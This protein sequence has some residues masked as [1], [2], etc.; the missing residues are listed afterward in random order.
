MMESSSLK[1]F[2]VLRW[3]SS[4]LVE[5]GRDHNAGEI[6]LQHLLDK[7]RSQLLASLQEPVHVQIQKRFKKAVKLHAAGKPVQ[8]IIGYE[9]FYG[10]RFLVN[11]HV[12]IPRPETEELVLGTLQRIQVA[13]QTR[14]NQKLVDV[15]TG[16]GIIAVTM[17]L[18]NPS[19]Q[20][21]A[22]D[23]S[24]QALEI[25]NKN[26]SQLQADVTFYQGDLCMPLIDRNE[27]FDIVLSNPPYIP[28]GDA[29]L[30]STVV[31]DHEPSQALF[32]GE[33]GL[34]YYRRIVD[35]LPKIIKENGLIVFEIG[36]EQ[37]KQVETILQAVFPNSSIE[38]VQDINEKDRFVFCQLLM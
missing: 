6:L 7:N 21:T 36:A 11:E 34:L 35:Q 14:L 23:I 37:G 12:L 33:D 38:I 18:E 4:F 9:M 16:S 25:A 26:A 29:K 15:G 17:K 1:V 8:Y 20:V 3:A 22:T 5:H 24:S 32:G 28:E 27:T 30:L 31:K 13:H 2:E 10:R 19:L